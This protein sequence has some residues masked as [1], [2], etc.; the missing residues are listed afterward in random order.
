MD[1]PSLTEKMSLH[2]LFLYISA[3]SEVRGY[4]CYN[5]KHN[6]P[7]FEVDTRRDLVSCHRNCLRNCLRDSLRD[8][9]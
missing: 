8:S 3:S 1:S 5:I 6:I 7:T 9:L 4:M 2:R